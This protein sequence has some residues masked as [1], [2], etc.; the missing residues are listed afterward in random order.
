M[1]SSVVIS[2]SFSGGT[3]LVAK[4]RKQSNWN[5][6]PC[7]GRSRVV[8]KDCWLGFSGLHSKAFSVQRF[9]DFLKFSIVAHLSFGNISRYLP[10]VISHF[11]KFVIFVHFT[12]NI[13]GGAAL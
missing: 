7:G 4:E 5:L 13:F 12:R 8:L 6:V 1:I 10:S 3:L 11:Q 9:Y 2:P